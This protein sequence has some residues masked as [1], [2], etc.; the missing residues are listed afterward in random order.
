MKARTIP[1]ICR[2]AGISER[3]YYVAQEV[4][5][6]GIPDLLARVRRGDLS[7]HLAAQI[8]RF[9]HD[10]QRQILGEFETLT[11]R[12]RTHMLRLM[13]QPATT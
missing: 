2:A 11:P 12:Q 7:L 6:K 9:Q 5:A 1:Q 10:T 3:M 4:H 13:L 8:C